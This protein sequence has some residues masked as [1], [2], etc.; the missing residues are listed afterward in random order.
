M[1][2]FMRYLC[3]TSNS[4]GTSSSVDSPLSS[5]IP[6]GYHDT[7]MTPDN[8]E[9]DITHKTENNYQ[10]SIKWDYDKLREPLKKT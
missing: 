3:A 2:T 8:A 6:A 1:H 10:N 9:R 5:F 4:K 7:A